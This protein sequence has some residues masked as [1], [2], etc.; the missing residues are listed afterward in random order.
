MSQ[1]CNEVTQGFSLLPLTD[2]NAAK[3]IDQPNG[4]ETEDHEHPVDEYQTLRI[5]TGMKV[6]SGHRHYHHEKPRAWPPE[7]RHGDHCGVIRE[8]G[9]IAS[10]Q[11]IDD[12]KPKKKGENEDQEC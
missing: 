2:E 12:D 9:E 7:I 5:P 11:F 4:H 6:D 1:H 3:L 8:K 10:H